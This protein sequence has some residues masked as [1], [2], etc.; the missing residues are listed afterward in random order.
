[1]QKAKSRSLSDIVEEQMTKWHHLRIE[2]KQ[3]QVNPLPCIT[4]SRDPGSGGTEIARR[5][6]KDL[7]MDLIG[8]RIIQQVSERADISEK[9][10]ASLD[11]KEVRRR[12]FWIDSM[13]RT[14]HIW[15]D[16]YLRY[17]TKVIGTIGKQ[18]NTIIIGRGDNSYCPPK[19]PSAFASSL[20]GR[21]VSAMS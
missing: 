4:I 8:S 21:S 16:E 7:E 1:M 17:L 9:V 2:Q 18:G 5:L 19:R 13:F 11:E 10:I 15:P 20:P 3:R 14:R 6:A 12:D